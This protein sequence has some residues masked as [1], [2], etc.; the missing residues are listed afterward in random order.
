MAGP[1]PWLR[2]GPEDAPRFLFFL[3]QAS[4]EHGPPPPPQRAVRRGRSELAAAATGRSGIVAAGDGGGRREKGRERRHKDRERVRGPTC[5]AR[6]PWP[7]PAWAHQAWSSG[8]D[9]NEEHAAPTSGHRRPGYL[10]ASA[11]L[12]INLSPSLPPRPPYTRQSESSPPRPR[13]SL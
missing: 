12:S 5:S 1:G 6:A 8:V 7:R 2:H 9:E 3:L 13:P 4:V 10:S 11:Q